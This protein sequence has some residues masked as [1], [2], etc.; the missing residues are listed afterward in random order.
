MDWSGP[1]KAVGSQGRLGALGRQSVVTELSLT[2]TFDGRRILYHVTCG[3]GLARESPR[4]RTTRK[5]AVSRRGCFRELKNG[6]GR[7]NGP[8][9]AGALLETW[10]SCENW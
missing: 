10:D 4:L 7:F 8:L 1:V 2:T 5:G 9:I 6:G 3:L